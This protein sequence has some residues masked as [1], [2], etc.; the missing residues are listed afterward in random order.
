MKFEP[1]VNRDAMLIR[2]CMVGMQM[3]AGQ[4]YN[5]KPDDLIAHGEWLRAQ[6]EEYTAQVVAKVEEIMD[7]EQ[8]KSK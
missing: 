4:R 3:Q 2:L 7:S 1:D 5:M 8:E 6:S